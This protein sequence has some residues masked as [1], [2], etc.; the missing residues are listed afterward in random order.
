MKAC[1]PETVLKQNKP[2]CKVSVIL[3][4]W[5]VRESFHSI[6]YLNRQTA[7]RSDYE[8][9]WLEFYDRKPD[10]LRKLVESGV[11]G[12][13]ALDQWIVAGYDRDILYSKHRL[14]NMG[15]LAAQGEICVIC[16]SDAI[17]TPT[18]IEKIISAF[19]ETPRAVIHLD[20]IRN[21][22]ERF[23]PFCHPSLDEIRGNGCFNW[24]GTVSV[25]L[26]NSP[27]MLHKANYGACMAAKR[28]RLDRGRRLRRTFGLSR[29]RV[30]AL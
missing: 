6:E 23:F 16:D 20:E 27:D 3:I 30:R 13:P 17:F 29:L 5:S 21:S 12:L 26:N 7:A 10:D 11:D 25:G 24:A 28:A 22:D 18:F 8:L 14:Y 4:D 1:K 15:I 2:G 9:I 19:T